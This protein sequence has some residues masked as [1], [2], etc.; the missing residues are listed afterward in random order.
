MFDFD[1]I[2]AT[3]F[4]IA[5]AEWNDCLSMPRLWCLA[6]RDPLGTERF[7]TLLET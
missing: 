3:L 6:N 5:L 2:I 1:K 4:F 7:A